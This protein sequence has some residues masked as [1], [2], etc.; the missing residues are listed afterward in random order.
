MTIPDSFSDLVSGNPTYQTK[1]HHNKVSFFRLMQ[2]YLVCFFAGPR[3]YLQLKAFFEQ[4]LA[5]NI[6]I[7]AFI[8][9]TFILKPEY[10][11]SESHLFILIMNSAPL[12][13]RR[14][15]VICPPIF[16]RICEI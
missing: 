15:A 2:D 1:I 13:V 6:K 16:S 10:S 4:M 3:G 11:I 7:Q 8:K 9:V 12:L 14:L 5:Q